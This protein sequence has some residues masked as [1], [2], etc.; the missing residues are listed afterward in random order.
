[1]GVQLDIAD[2]KEMVRNELAPQLAEQFADASVRKFIRLM[3]SPR[4]S[5]KKKPIAQLIADGGELRARLLETTEAKCA[6]RMRLLENVVR[7]YLQLVEGTERDEFTGHLLS[8]IWRYF[9]LT[10]A[11]PATNIPGR[12]LNYLVRD[13]AHPRHTVIGI[14]ALC[15]SPLQ[16]RERD[17]ELGVDRGS[18]QSRSRVRPRRS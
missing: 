18:L 14:A 1:V 9:R 17:T 6:E 3:E 5:T 8:D 4:L 11:I 2:Y 7:P 16:M 10:W 15:N 13:A 12:H